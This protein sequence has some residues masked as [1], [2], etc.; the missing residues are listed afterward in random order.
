MTQTAWSYACA[1]GYVPSVDLGHVAPRPIRWL[2]LPRSRS[3]ASALPGASPAC[4]GAE[5][6]GALR[7]ECR[8]TAWLECD[9]GG[10]RHW[11]LSSVSAEQCSP[12]LLQGSP[13]RSFAARA[14]LTAGTGC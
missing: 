13:I 14:L 12:W 2:S 11:L 9:Q 3:F 5:P 1:T 10:Y 6:T 7:S 8:E 4:A